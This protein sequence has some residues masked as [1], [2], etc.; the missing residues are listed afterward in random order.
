MHLV[1]ALVFVSVFFGPF[2][3]FFIFCEALW[4][5]VESSQ[6]VPVV[7][8]RP[9]ARGRVGPRVHGALVRAWALTKGW[10]CSRGRRVLVP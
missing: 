1:R 3:L 7:S 4:T 10:S 6:T 8:G 9:C 2:C 5:A